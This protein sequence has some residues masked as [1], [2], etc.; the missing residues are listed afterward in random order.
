[1]GLGLPY[2]A[3]G[4]PPPQLDP[5]LPATRKPRFQLQF[6]VEQPDGEWRTVGTTSPRSLGLAI[7]VLVLGIGVR[8]MAYAGSPV[9]ITPREVYLP[10]EQQQAGAPPPTTG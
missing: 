7:V 2:D 6:M 4:V 3:A 8:N 1:E 9:S 10:P 5:G